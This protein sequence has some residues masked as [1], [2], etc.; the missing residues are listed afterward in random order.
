MSK[1]L[2]KTKSNNIKD[3]LIAASGQI[4]YKD[5]FVLVDDED[6]FIKT[7]IQQDKVD[8]KDVD[9]VNNKD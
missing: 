9:E 3:F 7:Y 4:I 2:I 8:I 1:I 6:S 5:E